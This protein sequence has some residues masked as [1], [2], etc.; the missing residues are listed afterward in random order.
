[1]VVGACCSL[2]T[3][4][5]V[6]ILYEQRAPES[7][8]RALPLQRSFIEFDANVSVLKQQPFVDTHQ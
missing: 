5:P 3:A 4:V 8:R 7:D 1:L 6:A 2:D